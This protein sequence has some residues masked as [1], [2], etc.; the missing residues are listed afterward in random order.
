MYRL[1]L[2]DQRPTLRGIVIA[3]CGGS[4]ARDVGSQRS[5]DHDI[6]TA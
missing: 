1:D 3:A 5:A 4:G 2:T 6:V